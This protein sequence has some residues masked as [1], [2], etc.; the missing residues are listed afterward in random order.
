MAVSHV[1]IWCDAVSDSGR[2]CVYACL[3]VKGAS[4][5]ANQ[6]VFVCTGWIVS[7]LVVFVMIVREHVPLMLAERG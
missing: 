2:V 5:F 7:K 4:M 3:R 1:A 6:N